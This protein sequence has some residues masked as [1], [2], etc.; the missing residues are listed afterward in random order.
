MRLD[1]LGSPVV[2]FCPFDGLGFLLK[3]PEAKGYHYL[4]WFTGPPSH[5]TWNLNSG[6][7]I[8]GRDG[9]IL[10]SGNQRGFMGCGVVISV[11]DPSCRRLGGGGHW[12]TGR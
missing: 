8:V 4:E 5:Q 12:G 9:H 3:K 10:R 7:L 11:M 2:P 1:H 6:L